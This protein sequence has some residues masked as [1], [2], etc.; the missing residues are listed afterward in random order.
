MKTSQF[1]IIGMTC[2]SCQNSI[3]TKLSKTEG[4]TKYAVNLSTDTAQIT[5]HEDQLS[6]NDIK[7]IIEQVG[8]EA[9]LIENNKK[10]ISMQI[11]GMHCAACAQSI[12]QGV[13]K[14]PGIENLNV[15]V[16][17]NKMTVSYND[18]EVKLSEI[19]KKIH[20]LGYEAYFKHEENI[21]EDIDL[22]KTKKAKIKMLRSASIS[23]FIMI[24]MIFHMFILPIPFYTIITAILAAPVVFYFGFHVHQASFKSLKHGRPNMDVLVSLGSM[25]PYIIGLMGLFFPITTF[26]EMASTI[27]TFHLIGKYLETK[28]KGKASQ[29]IKKLIELGAKT[30]TIM[31]E[32]ETFEILTSELSVGDVMLI[33]PGEKIPSDGKII[34]GESL[35]DESLATGESMPVLRRV[36]D[37]VIGATLNKQGVL[38]VEVTKIGEDTFLA[39]VIKLVEACQGSKVPIQAFADRITGYFVPAI[40]VI[41]LLVFTSFLLFTNFHL[42]ILTFFEPL[43]PWIN[44]DQT[45]LTLAFITATAVLV[46]A[47]PCALGLGTPT[48][49]MV[50]SGIGAEN[51]ILIRHGEAVQTLK[52]IKAIAFDKTGTLTYGKPVITDLVVI[53]I[54]EE[55]TKIAQ[56]AVSLEQNSEHPLASAFLEYQE[57]NAIKTALVTNFEA[58]SGKGIKG[59][60][61]E[62]EYFLGNRKLMNE[63]NVETTDIEEIM[64]ALEMEA[65]TVMILATLDKIL[66]LFAVADQ[67][68]DEA[69]ETIE[70]IE[71]LGI[72]TYMIT[73][74]NE[75]T[76]K[77]IAKKANISH[78]IA[79]VMPDGKVDQIIKLQ[80]KYG[81]VAM[82]GDGINDA[83]AL[84]QANVGIALGTGVDIAIEAADVTLV[85]GDLQTLLGAIKLSK[86]IFRKI[87]E[88]YFWAWFYNAIAIPFAMLG[89]LHPMIGAAAM[90]LS[91]LNVI[92]NSLRLKKINLFN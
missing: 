15:N 84:K 43:L 71:R 64:N 90:S 10:T 4:I 60:I 20:D 65:K 75:Q 18:D 35:I 81:L 56:I 17:T 70:A 44:T 12:D 86:A 37:P 83:A 72:K 78:Y 74:D 54:N 63:I 53:N 29:A 6:A 27:M 23:A 62:T 92:Y 28:A 42:N 19:K 31:I 57:K 67:I 68:K 9:I 50:G 24:L 88:N 2:A 38:K 61:D 59:K 33:K 30:A 26:I 69:K 7:E 21:E 77:A 5:F 51:G 14:L 87:K 47:C 82:V 25:P 89:L 11:E 22:I 48:A 66:A 36:G 1:K 46:I 85:K 91:S 45:P 76:A 8:F 49:L 39:Q 13:S 32:E 73:G 3:E 80:E 52:D 34:F 55:E 40:M 79:E 58:V 16:L 41:T